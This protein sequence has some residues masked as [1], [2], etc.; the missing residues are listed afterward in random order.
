MGNLNVRT[1]RTKSVTAAED[2]WRIYKKALSF[3]AK[4]V[5]VTEHTAHASP[6]V[7]G[8]YKY[9]AGKLKKVINNF[10]AILNAVV[11]TSHIQKIWTCFRMA[12]FV[13][14]ISKNEVNTIMGLRYCHGFPVTC[15]WR[16]A[17]VEQEQKH[18]SNRSGSINNSLYIFTKVKQNFPACI[19]YVNSANRFTCYPLGR[20]TCSPSSLGH[21][22][23]NV[24]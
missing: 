19:R 17:E 6:W 4:K 8:L 15:V 23:W 20:L 10:L 9:Y 24:L 16:A 11:N 14:F 7:S 1:G 12:N 13:W 21:L 18:S 2:S 5:T 22:C 3:R